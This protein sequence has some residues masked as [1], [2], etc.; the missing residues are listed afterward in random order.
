MSSRK[1]YFDSIEVAGQ[2]SIQVGVDTDNDGLVDAPPTRPVEIFVSGDVKI[3]GGGVINSSLPSDF[4]IFASTKPSDYVE[5][6]VNAEFWTALPI[7]IRD[8]LEVILAEVTQ[9]GNQRSAQINR[10]DKEKIRSSGS[11]EIVS[12][13]DAELA[14]WRSAMLPVWSKFEEKIGAELIH[15]ANGKET[16][17]EGEG[18]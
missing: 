6:T 1:Y 7:G 2:A 3:A 16:E 14:V 10:E 18:D 13:S 4:R 12:L 11:S 15:V 5:V 17:A 8:E 9:W